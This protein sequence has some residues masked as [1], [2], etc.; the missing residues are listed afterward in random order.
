MLIIRKEQMG[1]LEDRMMVHLQRFFPQQ[2]AAL[3]ESGIRETIRYGIER[4]ESYGI[5]DEGDVSKYLDLMIVFNQDF[6]TSPETSRAGLIL[7]QEFLTD[8]A[9]KVERLCDEAMKSLNTV[10]C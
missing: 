1:V 8:P 4:A 2:S 3:G 6:D 9:S 7:N 5:V 10:N